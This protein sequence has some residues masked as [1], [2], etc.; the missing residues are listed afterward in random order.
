MSGPSFFQT[1]MGRQFFDATMPRL[2]KALERIA[3]RLEQ[4]PAAPRVVV[5][6]TDGG[7]EGVARVVEA[8]RNAGIAAGSSGDDAL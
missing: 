6:V 2:A 7:A 3:E 5:V 4:P 1:L 8:L